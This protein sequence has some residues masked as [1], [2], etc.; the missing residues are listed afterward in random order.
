MVSDFPEA[1]NCVLDAYQ[2]VGEQIP[3]LQGLEGHFA[4]S[5]LYPDILILIY[6]D[7]LTFH[8]ELIRLLKQRRECHSLFF[9]YIFD[10]ARSR[11]E[12]V[13]QS[14]LERLHS[15]S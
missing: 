11:I 3:R 8:G 7:I 2:G 1:L 15:E 5:S 10:L 14:A 13:V 4:S 12:K 9:R 6:K